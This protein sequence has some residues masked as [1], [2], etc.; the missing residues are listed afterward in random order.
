MS[1]FNFKVGDKVYYPPYSNKV[2]TVE[3]NNN[4]QGIPLAAHFSYYDCSKDKKA[5]SHDGLVTFSRNGR[6]NKFM[7]NPIIFPATQEWYDKLVQIYPN[8]EPPKE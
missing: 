3:D 6:G 1:D 8:L 4:F 5:F 2:L 7:K